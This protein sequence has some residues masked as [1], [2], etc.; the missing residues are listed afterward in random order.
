M[1]S[2]KPRFLINLPWFFDRSVLFRFP[3]GLLA[4][5]Q[6]AGLERTNGAGYSIGERR[7]V[8]HEQLSI[9]L[10][11][12]FFHHGILLFEWRET[13]YIYIYINAP[14]VH[15]FIYTNTH[16]A[17]QRIS[18]AWRPLTREIEPCDF[19]PSDGQPPSCESATR[20]VAGILR[21][22]N[23]AARPRSPVSMASRSD[24]EIATGPN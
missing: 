12:A 3:C 14:T 13:I 22:K 18:R 11:G 21:M 6:T 24:I 19:V 16:I 8:P 5:G 2:A 4:S 20:K 23:R 1:E 15:I 9:F 17:R 7:S 10:S